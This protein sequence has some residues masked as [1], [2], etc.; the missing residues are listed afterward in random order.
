MFTSFSK[1]VTGSLVD[2]LH[3]W[4]PFVID[5]TLLESNL[6]L[7]CV[8]VHRQ[9]K[10][11]FQ[12]RRYKCKRLLQDKSLQSDVTSSTQGPPSVTLSP[13]PVDSTPHGKTLVRDA[14]PTSTTLDLDVVIAADGRY[15]AS[16]S[17][18]TLPPYSS[19]PYNATYGGY[20]DANYGVND[21]AY[22]A[23][24]GTTYSFITGSSPFHNFTGVRA[25]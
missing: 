3:R 1:T 20:H 25:W 22:Y 24:S 11:W 8:M 21:A 17:A 13:P 23:N 6:K 19:L 9:V 12:N 5:R 16:P 2:S 4:L 18:S 7:N 15:D 10:I 14:C